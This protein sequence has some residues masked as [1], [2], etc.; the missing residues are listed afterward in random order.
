MKYKA[1]RSIT[2][3]ELIV[4]GTEVSPEQIGSP[5]EIERLVRLGALEE[6]QAPKAKPA[7]KTAAEKP[8]EKDGK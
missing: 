6:I 7:A 8:A 2:G 3:G 4:K 1:L 5:A